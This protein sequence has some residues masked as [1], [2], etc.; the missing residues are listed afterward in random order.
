MTRST[1]RAIASKAFLLKEM[2]V[3]DVRARYAGSGLGVLWAFAL[4]ILWMLLYTG[5]FS[6]VLK[7]PVES[8]YASFPEFLMAGLLPWMAISE[9]ISRSS[10][11]LIDNAAMVKKTVFPLET[12]VLSV[13]IAAVVNELIAFAVY[14]VYVA[15]VG[16]LSWPWL[17]LVVPALLFQV[18]LTFGLG[19]V[20]ATL[21]AFLR[22]TSHAVGIVLTVGFYATPIV[23]PLSLVPARLR[24]FLG[25][26]PVTPLVDLY[27]R[28][29]TL[30][31]APD[32]GSLAYLAAFS[33]AAAL[34]GGALFARARPH[35]ADLI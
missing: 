23:Y 5:V 14:G 9:G 33:V 17:L 15:L 11:C 13:V 27:R 28:A 26:N 18:L 22:D 3:R 12:L 6:L 16:H 35:F 2:V 30:H 7:V 24:P 19:C 4:P 20:A 32:P 34:A 1:S 31:A 8:G 10:S 21:T 29:F 25:A